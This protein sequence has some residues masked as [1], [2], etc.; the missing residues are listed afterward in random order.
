MGHWQKCEGNGKGKNHG[1]F[2]FK[3]DSN[4]EEAVIYKLEEG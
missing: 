3:M 2:T 1:T 4:I